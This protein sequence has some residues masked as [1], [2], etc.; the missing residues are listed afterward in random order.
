MKVGIFLITRCL[1]INLSVPYQLK[2]GVEC[3]IRGRWTLATW[4]IHIDT[5]NGVTMIYSSGNNDIAGFTSGEMILGISNTLSICDQCIKSR[6][7][8]YY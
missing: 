8:T 7:C 1:R 2:C 6:F 4:H 3:P 5:L